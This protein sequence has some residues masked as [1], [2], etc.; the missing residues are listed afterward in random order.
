VAGH[1]QVCVFFILFVRTDFVAAYRPQFLRY[2]DESVQAHC[3]GRGI[4]TFEKNLG[5]RPP[6]GEIFS[7]IFPPNF[8]L[9]IFFSHAL[10]PGKNMQ[11]IFLAP[12]PPGLRGLASEV[13]R[14]LFS[15][16]CIEEMRN[17]SSRQ[18]GLAHDNRLA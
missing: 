1:R 5:V 11:K 13:G 10:D 17:S 2:R 9:K 16:T 3:P 6:G 14:R 12:D 8:D 7:Q 15:S 4:D 18:V